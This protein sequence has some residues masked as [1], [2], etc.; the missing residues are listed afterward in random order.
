[1]EEIKEIK[2][3]PVLLATDNL[4][5]TGPVSTPETVMAG[6]YPELEPLELPESLTKKPWERDFD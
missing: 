2:K 4:A 3:D 6:Q 5:G 1:M